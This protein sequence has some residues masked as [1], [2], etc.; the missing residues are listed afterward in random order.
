MEYIF[1]AS[2]HNAT[3]G[4]KL[5]VRIGPDVDHLVV[6]DVNN[7]KDPIFVDSPFF[8][9]NIL[10]RVKDFHGIIPKGKKLIHSSPYFDD[11]KRLFSIQVQGRFKHNYSSEDIYFGAEFDRKVNPPTG[12]WMAIKFANY[13]DPA[14]KAELYADKPWFWS[15]IFASMNILNVVDLKNTPAKDLPPIGAH[16][17]ATKKGQNESE[18]FKELEK[19]KETDDDKSIFGPDLT[20]PITKDKSKFYS[21]SLLDVISKNTHQQDK[22]LGYNWMWEFP[23]VLDEDSSLL[24]EDIELPFETSDSSS[25]RKY[26][27]DEDNRK[28]IDIKADKGYNMEIFA[29][30]INMNTFD[31]SLGISINIL[32]YL[33]G[34][35]VRM[36]AKSWKSDKSLFVVEFDLIHPDDID[37]ETEEVGTK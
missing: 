34:Q 29:P 33:E 37:T 23:K 5:R 17:N 14:L 27:G 18:T 7:D 36:V 12:A 8:T 30:F 28:S 9:G 22:L 1:G 2:G 3:G 15:P 19:D 25:R 21:G 6:A 16:P 13:I 26:F 32:K 35:P 31:L 11:K 4:R 20:I 24:S 10:V